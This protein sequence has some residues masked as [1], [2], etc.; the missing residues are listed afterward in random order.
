[1]QLAQER[2]EE[3][4]SEKMDMFKRK[5]R[6]KLTSKDIFGV[7]QFTEGLSKHDD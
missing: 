5:C 4:V 2:G 6:N 3:I 7:T 1:M